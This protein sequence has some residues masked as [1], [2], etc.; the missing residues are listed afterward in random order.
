MKCLGLEKFFSFKYNYLINESIIQKSLDKH[1]LKVVSIIVEYVFYN[2][3]E[4]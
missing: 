3:N 1:Q 4:K 2:S